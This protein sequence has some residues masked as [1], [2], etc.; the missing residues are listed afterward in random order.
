MCSFFIQLF[1]A[2]KRYEKT[3]KLKQSSTFPQTF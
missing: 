2:M 3:G 1:N